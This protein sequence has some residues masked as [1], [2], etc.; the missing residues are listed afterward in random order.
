M[1]PPAF[2]FNLFMEK[3]R[4]ATNGS[5]F[6][7]WDLNLR[8]LLKAA[9]KTYVLD[10]PLGAPPADDA[11]D[12]EKN[13][14]LTRQ[15]DHSL[16]HCGILYGLEPELR[17]RF[18]NSTAYDTMREL[19]MIFDSHAAVE[20][21][22]ASEKFFSCMMEEHSSVSEHVLRM[23]GY[24][25]KLIALGI[26]IPIE[27]GIHRVLQSLPP[28]YKSFVMNYNMQGM[29]K[30]LPE[31]LSM[32]KT[33]E[34]EI[35]K[36]HQ[37]LMVNK[38]TS[39]KKKGKKGKSKGNFKKDGKSVAISEKKTKAGPK[40]DTECFYCKG[41]GHWKRNCPK[42][43]ADKKD[44]KVNKGI[45]D[46]HV[47]DVYLTSSRSSAWVF[48]T[49][50]VANICNSKQGLRNS[51]PLARDE[52]TMRVGNGSKVDVIAV[53]TLPLHLPSGLVINLNKC[54]LVPALS[55]NIISGSCL[56]Q[57]GYSFMSENN[58]CSFYMNNIFYGHAPEKNGLFLLNLDSSS[59][60]IHNV[61]AKRIKLNDDIA[62]YLWHCR[63][64]H[65]GVKRMKKLH[66]DGLL[67]SLDYESFET[68]EP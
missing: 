67:E 9:Q 18:E 55:M 14:F 29:K 30:S 48:D 59:T 24:A 17:K 3:E 65:I 50:S 53:G 40:P 36:E 45:C 57:D 15:E 34:V 8:I 19:K 33:A 35:K 56:L 21:Y 68:C 39:F 49:G 42:Y 47:I 27:L 37:V 64:G 23:S 54:Y 6:T 2:N 4:L 1:A 16:V 32:L 31:L 61:N 13:V 51:R 12:E 7:N 63:L 44:G 52:V 20:S 62:A 26:S 41:T 5:N 46:I 38:T 22:E 25:D 43:L 10:A 58:G 60:H 11:P 28:S 66:S